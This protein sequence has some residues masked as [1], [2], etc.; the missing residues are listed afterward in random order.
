MIIACDRPSDIFAMVY[1]RTKT[2]SAFV[3]FIF[4]LR[5]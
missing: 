4:I 3:V 5:M 1:L 2:A